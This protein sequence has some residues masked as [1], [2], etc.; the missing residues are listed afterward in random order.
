ME[1]LSLFS[2]SVIILMIPLTILSF[3]AMKY[4][5]TGTARIAASV[6]FIVAA[7]VTFVVP[8]EFAS[9]PKNVSM[10]WYERQIE[11]ATVLWGG[12]HP[13][14][15]EIYVLLDWEEQLFPRYYRLNDSKS[16]EA[17]MR[18]GEEL[19]EAL[20]KAEKSKQQG[21]S[22]KITMKYPFLSA[23]ERQIKLEEDGKG[24]GE[25]DSEFSGVEQEDDNTFWVEPPPP[26]NPTKN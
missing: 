23:D 6:F 5:R 19:Q 14:T 18:L 17:E 26:P 7:F 12:V 15:K 3:V 1:F 8:L 20:R 21:G 25:G 24:K 2:F 11:E 9:F 22:G 4:V 13:E 16:P 10:E